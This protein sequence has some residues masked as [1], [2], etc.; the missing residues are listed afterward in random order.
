[1]RH[2]DQTTAYRAPWRVSRLNLCIY[3]LDRQLKS[4][5]AAFEKEGGFTERLYKLRRQARATG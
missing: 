3:L 5:A 2:E 1:L 4:Q